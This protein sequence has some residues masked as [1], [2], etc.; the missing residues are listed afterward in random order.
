VMLACN[1]VDSIS[2]KCSVAVATRKSLFQDTL[3]LLESLCFRIANPLT[4][5]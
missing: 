5:V 2:L 3:E 1:V 4:F